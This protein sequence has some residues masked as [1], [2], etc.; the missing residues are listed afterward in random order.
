MGDYV[1]EGRTNL[2]NVIIGVACRESHLPIFLFTK[3]GAIRSKA[4]IVGGV[5]APSMSIIK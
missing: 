2:V 4:V 5:T 3:D 1:T